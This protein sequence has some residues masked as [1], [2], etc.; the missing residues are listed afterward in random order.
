M[1]FH[2]DDATSFES[3][4]AVRFLRKR[5]ENEFD[6]LGSS[7]VI[8]EQTNTQRIS[9][10]LHNRRFVPGFAQQQRGRKQ[11]LR[12]VGRALRERAFIRNVPYRNFHFLQQFHADCA[13]SGRNSGRVFA[14]ERLKASHFPDRSAN[15]SSSPLGRANQQFRSSGANCSIAFKFV[16]SAKAIHRSPGQLFERIWREQGEKIA[17]ISR[18]ENTWEVLGKSGTCFPPFAADKTIYLNK[19]TNERGR[20]ALLRLCVFWVRLWRADAEHFS[21]LGKLLGPLFLS[22]LMFCTQF[23]ALSASHLRGGRTRGRRRNCRA[24]MHANA[25]GMRHNR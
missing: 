18:D 9:Q 17:T 14:I 19:A 3:I 21:P 24:N 5:S 13:A 6:A 8:R 20:F 2:C 1:L 23:V 4:N 15:A 10:E 16:N 22:D 12:D 25:N 11:T 7:A